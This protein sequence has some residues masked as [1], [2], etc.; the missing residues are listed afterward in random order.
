M[1]ELTENHFIILDIISDEGIEI[2]KVYDHNPS[3]R[4]WDYR[5]LPKLLGELE[6]CSL[7]KDEGGFYILT[8]WGKK[9]RNFYA[10]KKRQEKEKQEL[11]LATIRSTYTTNVLTWINVGITLVLT[12]LIVWLQFRADYREQRREQQETRKE[13]QEAKDKSQQAR[14]DSLYEKY[15]LLKA[16]E[17][18]NSSTR[19]S[20]SE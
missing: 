20:I 12:G 4:L 11:E 16:L 14:H 15:L 3:D 7:I 17:T 6:W 9:A 8:D 5:N 2:S 1:E 10:D 19:G 13:Q 18:F